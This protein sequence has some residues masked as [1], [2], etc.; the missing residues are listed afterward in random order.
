MPTNP[1]AQ[2]FWRKTIAGYTGSQYQEE[3]GATFLGPEHVIFR[4]SNE[5]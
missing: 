4:F 1:R 3:H 5:I 2:G